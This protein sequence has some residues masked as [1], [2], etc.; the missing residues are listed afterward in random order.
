MI[1]IGKTNL[2]REKPVPLPPY[3]TNLTLGSL[4]QKMGH[5]DTRLVTIQLIMDNLL[6]LN[7]LLSFLQE[8]KECDV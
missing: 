2:L 1:L 5:H 7:N 3:D 6:L 4:E 8:K